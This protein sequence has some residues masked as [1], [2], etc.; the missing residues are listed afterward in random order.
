MIDKV[1]LPFFVFFFCWFLY[2][3]VHTHAHTSHIQNC[4]I[5][6]ICY[7]D[8]K[9]KKKID[10]C[11][12]PILGNLLEIFF[13]GDLNFEICRILNKHTR[14]NKQTKQKKNTNFRVKMSKP[15]KRRR[16]I[17]SETIVEDCL[18]FKNVHFPINFFKKKEIF[19]KLSKNIYSHISSFFYLKSFCH[20]EN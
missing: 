6:S 20:H 13:A 16:K 11:S 18:S 7:P 3:Q 4:F 2:T 1:V 12:L 5:M 14:T 19:Q 9:R 8:S 10:C 15:I 17:N